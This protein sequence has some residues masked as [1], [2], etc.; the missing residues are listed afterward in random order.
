LPW[1]S[2]SRLA[3][4][5]ARPRLLLP[6][7]CILLLALAA[8]CRGS[9]GETARGEVTDCSGSASTR[10]QVKVDD[11]RIELSTGQAEP[12]KIAFVVTYGGKG[13]H[14]LVVI[15]S[16]ALPRDLPTRDG[17][18]D[19]SAVQVM[20]RLQT[21]ASGSTASICLDLSRGKYYLLSNLGAGGVNDFAQGMVAG[22]VV[23]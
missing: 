2:P 13:E 18:L 15:R 16:D 11:G 8:A 5:V 21:M 9:G 12:G 1:F 6:A 19:E 4:F 14:E 3:G 20:G 23:E 10:V 7:A 22:F 17:R